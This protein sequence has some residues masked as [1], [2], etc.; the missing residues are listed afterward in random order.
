[1]TYPQQL[2][3]FAPQ[4][5]WRPPSS[6]PDLSGA[7]RIAVDCETRDPYLEKHGPGWFHGDPEF[8][9][10]AGIAVAT[11]Q[12]KGYFPIAHGYGA[13]LDRRM[14]L[15]WLKEQL[16]RE[17]QV[18]VFHNALYDLGWL[19]R[20]GVEVY[21]KIHDTMLAAPLID[22]NRKSYSLDNLGK[23]WVGDRK[24]ERL[25]EEAGLAW[26]LGKGKSIKKNMWKLPASYVGPY[27]EQDAALTLK[28]YDY[29]LKELKK[30]E[31]LDV[32]DLECRLLPMLLEMRWRGVRVDVTKAE[33][34]G[35]EFKA[36]RD[37]ALAELKRVT[38]M[39]VDVWSN[40]SL[41]LVYRQMSVKYPVTEKGN[42]SFTAP[43]LEAQSDP[44]S[45]LVVKA[46]KMDRAESTFSTGMILE[47][48]FNGRLHCQ[49]HQLKNDDYGT[50]SYRFSSS[51]PNL[52]QVPARDPY[53]GPLIRS[54]FIPDEGGRWAKF[55]Y[56]QQ[57]PRLTVHYAELLKL[58]GA[59]EAGDYLRSDPNADFHTLVRDM[60]RRIIPTF[61]RKP[62]KTINLGKAY[63]MGLD[64]LCDR[65]GVTKEQGKIIV[66]AYDE[67][68]PIIKSLTAECGNRA[69]ERGFIKT[70]TGHKCRFGQWE[71]RDWDL[72]K[73]VKSEDDPDKML[74]VVQRAI[75]QARIER[76]TNPSAEVPRGGVRRAF[77]YRA[78]NRL[79]QGSAAG[80]TKKAMVDLW[81][82]TEA[83]QH[84][85]IPHLQV[86][87]ELDFTVFEPRHLPMIQQIM[88]DAVKLT[89]P[90]KC[91]PS[92]GPDWGHVE[93]DYVW[94]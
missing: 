72:A 65:L 13:N 5:N 52:Q 17:R 83:G 45:S 55:D 80:Q 92:V 9:E 2:P 54:L 91:D 18:K 21:G 26:G 58:A 86:H 84:V 76:Q 53:L 64:S 47:H 32:F 20:S 36:E 14:V 44:L 7:D 67:G 43:W 16:S 49:F 37:R 11:D 71:P 12:F 48:A 19:R 10:V 63:G 90:V 40:G 66:D 62:A 93:D 57:E 38:G 60:V 25:L 3:L 23:D 89:V 24:D 29:C 22:E 31:L 4:S 73:Q 88:V 70:I 68:F 74:A 33:K 46:R 35:E 42:S 39:N 94:E 50:I 85:F 56:S 78:M 15:K 28:L 81:E 34:M 75:E 59:Q 87:D 30:Q 8:G 61:D 51:N 79:I 82:Y 77:T 1:M 41:E 6:F 69:T 27:A